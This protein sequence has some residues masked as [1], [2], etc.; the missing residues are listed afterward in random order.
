MEVEK[1]PQAKKTQ[2]RPSKIKTLLITFFD[3]KGIIFEECIPSD[4]TVTAE[5]YLKVLK[6]LMARI[7]HIRPEY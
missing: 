4:Q 5:H 3:N 2:K 7:R 6:R 1:L